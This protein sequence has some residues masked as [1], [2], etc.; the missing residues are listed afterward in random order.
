MLAVDNSRL[1]LAEGVTRGEQVLYQLISVGAAWGWSFAAT[2]L[3][4]LAIKVTMGLR[5]RDADEELGLDLSQHDEVAY[6][7]TEE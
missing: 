7:Y 5:L 1:V 2:G 3:I 6:T 4:L